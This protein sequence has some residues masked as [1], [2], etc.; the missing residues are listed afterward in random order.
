M[1]GIDRSAVRRL[2]SW[3]LVLCA[4][5][6][7]QAEVV[8]YTADVPIQ[9]TSW[10]QT[11][12]L[13]RFNPALG[14]LQGIDVVLESHIEGT[15]RFEN[16]DP[17]PA[18]IVTSFAALM[19]LKRPDTSAFI[20][21][22][23]PA[24]TQSETVAAY[25][26]VLDFGGASGRTI[27]GIN[28]NQS[29]GFAPLLPLS[30]VDQAL[31]VGGGNILFSVSASGTSTANGSGNLVVNFTQRA[32]ARVTITYTYEP[33]FFPDCNHNGVLDTT[34]VANGTSSD[35]DGDGLP[36]ECEIIGD[37]CNDNGIPD[38]CDFLS[39]VLTDVDHDGVPDQCTCVAVDRSHG[40]SLLVFPE[41]DHRSGSETLL[42][43]TNTSCGVS[44]Q[45]IRV[46]FVFIEAATCLET[47]RTAILSPCDT[48]SL[49][50]NTYAGGGTR[51]YVYAF[52]KSLRAGAPISFNW[53]IGSSL[54][55]DGVGT[56]DY[57]LN[58]VSFRGIPQPDGALTDLDADGIRDLNGHEYDPAPDVLLVPRF[59]GQVP[60][61]SEGSQLVLVNLTGG[62]AF[63]AT[64]GLQVFNDNE[65]PLYAQHTFRCW[66]K[67]TLLG[68]NGAFRNSVLLDTNHSAVEVEGLAERETGWIRID[69]VIAI[70]QQTE[71][72]DPAI[73]AVLIERGRGYSAA[74]L[75]W[76]WCSQTNGDLLPVSEL[77]DT[78]P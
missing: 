40:A 54:V 61:E 55:V 63:M 8:T 56:L 53:L 14:E 64:I 32:S 71:I 10:T 48:F 2:A 3:T 50:G 68:I 19:R 46:E 65:E 35:C 26:N 73:L 75:P 74:D 16:R 21:T 67:P 22:V 69:G 34:D 12:P 31:F 58:A 39:G 78:T 51:G 11:A 4:A 38:P 5:T 72:I 20:V 52:A 42:T 45:S 33:P 70:S 27:N 25:D 13:P 1:F 24:F 29:N 49:V 76:E 41:Y 43:V 59:L 60:P 36:D 15:A 7:V 9:T 6:R 47:N 30:P 37:D 62:R 17:V 23:N 44:G 18:T 28:V 57:A 77:G 66:D